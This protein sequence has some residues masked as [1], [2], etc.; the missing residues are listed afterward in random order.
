MNFLPKLLLDKDDLKRT[1]N[2]L[3]LED[4]S[5]PKPFVDKS[6]SKPKPK[7]EEKKKTPSAE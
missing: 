1:I 6:V 2:S 3:I 4:D 5:I 7:V